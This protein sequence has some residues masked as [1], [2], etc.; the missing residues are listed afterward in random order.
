MTQQLYYFSEF[1]KLLPYLVEGMA[2]NEDQGGILMSAFIF[3]AEPE[4]HSF[5]Y[6]LARGGA[7]VGY[8]HLKGLCRIYDYDFNLVYKTFEDCL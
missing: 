6:N 5:W 7:P 1:K 8:E 4:G 3:S 2:L